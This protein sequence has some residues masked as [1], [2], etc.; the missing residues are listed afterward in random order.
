[1]A[2]ILYILESM[3]LIFTYT[4]AF[5]QNMILFLLIF[6]HFEI[7]FLTSLSEC[8]YFLVHFSRNT[9]II[10][11]GYFSFFVITGLAF[12][13]VKFREFY[14]TLVFNEFSLKYISFLK[15]VLAKAQK[16]YAYMCFIFFHT[17]LAFS[18]FHFMMLYFYE[19][20]RSFEFFYQLLNLIRLFFFPL[21]VVVIT[22]NFFPNLLKME[23]VLG[24]SG[25]KILAQACSQF[26]E[27]LKEH[28]NIKKNPK[29]QGLF[30]V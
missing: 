14:L 27:F 7:C 25:N 10:V 22:L 18:V 29:P 2:Q 24:E 6:N 21:V 28:G 20:D 26:L 8:I 3:E 16:K 11:C 13:S 30:M 9:Y 19:I 4:F 12:F 1:M 23:E 17:Y 15:E 5:L